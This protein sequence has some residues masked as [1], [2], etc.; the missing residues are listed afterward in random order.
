VVLGGPVIGFSFIKY[1][2]PVTILVGDKCRPKYFGA[3]KL[4]IVLGKER[5]MVFY[6]QTSY[7]DYLSTCLKKGLF[8]IQNYGELNWIHIYTNKVSA[9]INPSP[10]NLY[11]SDS[12]L[13][14]NYRHFVK[15]V[16]LSI[17]LLYN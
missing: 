4:S 7:E 14:I 8:Y 3:K 17:F 10:Q 5:G 11:S 6:W 2:G 15:A 16:K 9:L 13:S 12:Y 1:R